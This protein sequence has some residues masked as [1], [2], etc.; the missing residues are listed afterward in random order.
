MAGERRE[1]GCTTYLY[2]EV[3]DGFARVLMGC[4]PAN[5]EVGFVKK[6]CNESPYG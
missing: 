6:K 3:T 2:N 4:A 5:S 1:V